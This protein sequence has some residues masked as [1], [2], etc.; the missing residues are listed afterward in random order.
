MSIYPPFATSA[1]HLGRARARLL[2]VKGGQRT[3]LTNTHCRAGQSGPGQRF[4]FT[5]M[6]TPA[7]T[8]RDAVTAVPILDMRENLPSS[9]ALYSAWASYSLI[10]AQTQICSGLKVC[11]VSVAL[12]ARRTPRTTAGPAGAACYGCAKGAG[13]SRRHDDSDRA[14]GTCALL[15]DGIPM[16]R[17]Q[18]LQSL[19]SS[20]DLNH[21]RPTFE[22]RGRLLRSLRRETDRAGRVLAH[23]KCRRGLHAQRGYNLRYIRAT[24]GMA[25]QPPKAA[26][27]SSHLRRGG[28]TDRPP[29]TEAIG[30]YRS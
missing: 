16:A 20:C 7:A 1:S 4:I 26:P 14:G 13:S 28:P 15:K 3:G 25:V 21:L 11:C 24:V 23:C 5:L 17:A 30:L 22:K 6:D 2:R 18:R 19:T 8:N 12:C 10:S 9:S 27:V 29:S